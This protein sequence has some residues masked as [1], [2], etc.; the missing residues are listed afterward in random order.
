MFISLF[1]F[2]FFAAMLHSLFFI[3]LLRTVKLT[4]FVCLFVR[5]FVRFWWKVVAT[6]ALNSSGELISNS[7]TKEDGKKESLNM[8]VLVCRYTYTALCVGA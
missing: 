4:L 7:H 3:F 5:S 1:L 6:K 2:C 8:Y